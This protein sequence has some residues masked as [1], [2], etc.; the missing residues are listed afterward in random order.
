MGP[1]YVM[2]DI[3]TRYKLHMRNIHQV[4]GVVGSSTPVVAPL[5]L[6]LLPLG[7]PLGRFAGGSPEGAGSSG[8]GVGTERFLELNIP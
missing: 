6:F 4:V 5:P 7:L 8:F 3:C 1:T 2:S